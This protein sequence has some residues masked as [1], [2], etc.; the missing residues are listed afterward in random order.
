[1]G[2]NS[3][4]F[5]V[6]ACLTPF[7]SV[8][9]SITAVLTLYFVQYLH[10]DRDLSTAVYHAFSS[11]CY[12]T[13]VLGAIIAD[14]W[15][16][17][18]LSVVYVIGH[19]VKSVGAIPTVGSTTEHIGM[20]KKNPPEG[21]ILLDVCKC[22][23][24]AINRRVR[25]SKYEAKRKH[26]LDWAEE[27]YSKRLIEEIK[28]VLRVLVLYIPL[29][30]F[31]ALFDQQTLNALLILVFVPIFDIIIYPLVALCR[32]NITPVV[33]SDP[34][35]GLLNK[36]IDSF[37]VAIECVLL[38]T[39]QKAYSL[40]LHPT[41]L[42]MQCDLV[43]DYIDKDPSGNA[44]LRYPDV[45]CESNNCTTL[46]LGLL[47]FGGVYTF[48]L[49]EDGG[50]IV[51]R[52]FEDV[53]ANNVHISWQVPHIC[54]EWSA[55][56]IYARSRPCQNDVIEAP[57]NMKSVLQAGWLLTVA[58]GN[59][60]V[61]IVAEGAGLQQWAEFAL[62]AGLLVVVCVI[63][64]IMAHF[65]TYVDPSQLDK[66]YQDDDTKGDGGDEIKEK[67]Q[68]QESKEKD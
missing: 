36:S 49:V 61:L 23:G 59:I 22:I 65:Y 56:L 9:V 18:Y 31:W 44:F 37:Q 17:I 15:T 62:F 16:I 2:K 34:G 57:A 45:R 50:K 1:M 6:S 63:F 7:L 39:E 11:L 47:D 43:E 35:I 12:F 32:V 54:T 42:G 29:P 38:F 51:A 55:L 14:S 4:P 58:F 64:S 53:K 33:L 52:K 26:W 67:I 20:Y 46:D 10:W 30:M 41:E 68:D 5:G 13:P 48:V 21:N 28:M 19:V 25:S 24:F 60:I 27:K 3:P 40:I 8:S 66:L